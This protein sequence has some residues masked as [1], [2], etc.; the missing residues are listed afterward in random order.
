[1][2]VV[3]TQYHNATMVLALMFAAMLTAVLAAP[4]GTLGIPAVALAWLAIVNVGVI[5]A[6]NQLPALGSTLPPPNPTL[7]PGL[8]P[9]LATSGP[10]SGTPTSAASS[11]A[12]AVAEPP[13]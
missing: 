4:P 13:A 9:V 10:L 3:K 8:N 11:A 2:N 1:M 7:P 6:V 12:I 5:V